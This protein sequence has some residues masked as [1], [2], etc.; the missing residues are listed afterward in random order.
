[1]AT[2]KLK[3]S[4]GG[5]EAELDFHGLDYNE[6]KAYFEPQ[7]SNHDCWAACLSNALMARGHFVTLG[8]IVTEFPML[9]KEGPKPSQYHEIANLVIQDVAKAKGGKCEFVPKG[10]LG[11]KVMSALNPLLE[12]LPVVLGVNNDS[13]VI[14]LAAFAVWPEKKS[15]AYLIHEPTSNDFRVYSLDDYSKRWGGGDAFVIRA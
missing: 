13:H 14:L 11:E 2:F 10:I 5:T 3:F 7:K 6:I 12:G 8:Q 4:S 9:G 1:M 15:F